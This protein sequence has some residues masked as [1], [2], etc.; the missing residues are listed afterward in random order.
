MDQMRNNV[1]QMLAEQPTKKAKRNALNVAAYGSESISF[2]ENSALVRLLHS[3]QEDGLIEYAAERGSQGL[4]IPG[5]AKIT[6]F[7][8]NSLKKE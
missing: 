6:T 7:G 5:I 1:L 8:T 4:E 3:L 2:E